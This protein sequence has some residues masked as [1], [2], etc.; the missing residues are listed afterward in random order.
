MQ[1]WGASKGENNTKG[2]NVK[3]FAYMVEWEE[4]VG[5]QKGIHTARETESQCVCD[6]ETEGDSKNLSCIF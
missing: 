1:Y 4:C 3:E 5:I 2:R 6:S